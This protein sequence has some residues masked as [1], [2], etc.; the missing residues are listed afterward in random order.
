MQPLLAFTSE[1]IWAA[2]P[3][4]A[5]DDP[6]CVLLG[7]IP[8]YDESL[9]LSDEEKAEWDAVI[10][11]RTDVNKALELSRAQ[12]IVGKPLDAE[13]TLYLSQ[14]G[15]KALPTDKNGSH[16]AWPAALAAGF[17]ACRGAPDA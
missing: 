2:M 11:L 15:R 7:D 12:K 13:I 1:E 10:A 5:A 6:S 3:H 8:D 17:F 9:T 4:S 14:E 16:P